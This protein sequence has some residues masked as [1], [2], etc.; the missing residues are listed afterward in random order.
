LVS[1]DLEERENKFWEICCKYLPG[2]YDAVGTEQRNAENC[3]LSYVYYHVSPDRKTFHGK[4]T[5]FYE[6]M[7]KDNS[8][9]LLHK[10]ERDNNAITLQGC[11]FSEYTKKQ[12]HRKKKKATKSWRLSKTTT[13]LEKM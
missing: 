2:L 6:S 11:S 5:F 10:L 13:T 9:F 12:L 8:H 3:F 4:S 1:V 7:V